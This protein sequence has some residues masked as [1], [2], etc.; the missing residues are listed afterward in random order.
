M[1][2]FDNTDKF[3]LDKF[4]FM[5]I[6]LLVAFV[7]IA[8]YYVYVNCSCSS[9]EKYI[10][11]DV[12]ALQASQNIQTIENADI[13]SPPNNT[14]NPP[15]PSPSPSPL[16]SITMPPQPVFTVTVGSGDNSIGYTTDGFNWIGVDYGNKIFTQAGE[17]VAFNGQIYVAVGYGTN[18]I[19]IST[20]GMNWTGLGVKLFYT[21]YCVCWNG[22]YFFAGGSTANN[23]VSA[24][25][26][27]SLALI[28]YS[29]DGINWEPSYSINMIL[30]QVF[31]I[32]SNTAGTMMV[33][34]G[35]P[36]YTTSIAYSTDGINWLPADTTGII[37]NNI[38]TSVCWNG[39]MFVAGGQGNMCNIAFSPDGMNWTGVPRTAYIID[40][41]ISICTNGSMFVAVGNAGIGSTNSSIL[42]SLDS[43]D[44]LSGMIWNA[45]DY[46]N[47]IFPEGANSVIWNGSNFVA[48]G[49]DLT[50]MSIIMTS[51]DGMNWVISNSNVIFTSVSGFCWS[52]I[53]PF[54]PAYLQPQYIGTE[55]P[56]GWLTS[57]LLLQS[58]IGALES[59]IL[60]VSETGNQLLP[61]RWSGF[62][63]TVFQVVSGNS[64]QYTTNTVTG[65]NL[66]SFVSQQSHSNIGDSS[67]VSI[68]LQ[69]GS[70]ML[71]IYGYNISTGGLMQVSLNGV[72]QNAPIDY[73]VAQV[74][75]FNIE[76]P[77][78]II[79]RMPISVPQGGIQNLQ[80]TCVGTSGKGYDIALTKINI[81]PQEDISLF[82]TQAD[83]LPIRWSGFYDEFIV[84][85]GD[86]ILP[87]AY[88]SLFYQQS[89]QGN[90]STTS[91]LL[92]KG[93]YNLFIMGSQLSSGG[94]LQVSLND[95]NQGDVIDFYSQGDNIGTIYLS[96]P[97]LVPN[98]GLQKMTFTCVGKNVNS[99][100]YDILISKINII[101]H[102]DTSLVAQQDM[103][104]PVEWS[105]FYDEFLVVYGNPMV[106]GINQNGI[107]DFISKQTVSQ[108]GD[109]STTSFLLKQGYYN[110]YLMGNK[111]PTSGQLQVSLNGTNQGTMI[112]LYSPSISTFTTSV[113]I[114]VKQ[115]GLQML[116]FTC[117]G[118]NP[119]SSG[120]DIS[121]TY[122][123]IVQSALPTLAPSIGM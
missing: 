12:P 53:L 1:S 75:P 107:F 71:N 72:A 33:A 18:C 6:F 58:E 49:V 123:Y 66:F 44:T 61:M 57:Q 48:G 28:M 16:A 38:G 69:K 84:T 70:Y 34:T 119:S 97:L 59:E 46:E 19:A 88:E 95:I 8:I 78:L 3:N 13:I 36:S 31:S 100:S 115:G 120:Y 40:K 24:P 4:D 29:S 92:Q 10:I 41:V 9:S 25:E 45:V 116:Q 87:V 91:F 37:F 2:N 43:D 93:S 50:G 35:L 11:Y 27:A 30:G 47:V 117:S 23:Q 52:G 96:I 56:Q 94:K 77:S 17:A 81:V 79:T 110:L 102:S 85:F 106:G 113:P 15:S 118:Q 80:F 105:G 65:N 68:I 104:L 20:D 89:A 108:I 32:C 63:G 109:S 5:I 60:A 76:I 99:G 21:A 55:G 83:P 39:S 103:I 67:V 86:E 122:M 26:D 112:D 54:T 7:V 111:N 62:Y 82:L 101:P 64:F 22:S 14:P 114:M 73:S 90:S 42:Y 121:L 51:P 98:G 74:V